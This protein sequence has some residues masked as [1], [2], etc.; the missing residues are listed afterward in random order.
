MWC[1]CVRWG[2]S[3]CQSGRNIMAAAGGQ[4]PFPSALLISVVH[5]DKSRLSS[6]WQ[7]SAQMERLCGVTQDGTLMSS[8]CLAYRLASRR[9]ISDHSVL[10]SSFIPSHLLGSRIFASSPAGR[11]STSVPWQRCIYSSQRPPERLTLTDELVMGFGDGGSELRHLR[12]L[13]GWTDGWRTQQEAN[14]A[15]ISWRWPPGWTFIRFSSPAGL[16]TST[17]TF[18]AWELASK[19]PSFY[20][21]D[22]L[23]PF[24]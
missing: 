10:I 24:V 17:F 11:V 8:T 5:R 20:S 21:L 9:D 2:R 18:P 23:N 16:Q 12:K 6:R 13:E 14:R 7:A 4:S 22:Y 19:Q 1:V 3:R 15:V